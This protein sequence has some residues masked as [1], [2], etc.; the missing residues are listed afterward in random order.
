M[1]QKIP[2]GFKQFNFSNVTV[3]TG[4][5]RIKCHHEKLKLKL[6]NWSEHLTFY[7]TVSKDWFTRYTT[8]QFCVTNYQ[9]NRQ[10]TK[11]IRNTMCEIAHKR[12]DEKYA[13]CV[14]FVEPSE[15]PF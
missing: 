3:F 5:I 9:L 7:E 11:A 2:Y 10:L 6:Q 12:I 13:D 4:K 8:V 15:L 1:Q 14:E